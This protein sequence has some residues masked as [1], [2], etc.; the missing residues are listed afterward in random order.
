MKS[1]FDA[2]DLVLT[3]FRMEN[4]AFYELILESDSFILLE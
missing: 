1:E 2:W 3:T 4:L